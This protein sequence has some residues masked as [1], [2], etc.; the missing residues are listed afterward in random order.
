[1]PML[2]ATTRANQPKTAIPSVTANH[3]RMRLVLVMRSAQHIAYVRIERE[4][5]FSVARLWLAC[6][7]RPRGFLALVGIEVGFAD[8]DGG[9]GDF[10]EF[11]VF[12]P[13]HGLFERQA[14]RGR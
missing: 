1:M 9:G 7:L 13:G 14:A 11:V 6:F 8:A 2:A 5:D 10:D 12:D 3:M 4:A